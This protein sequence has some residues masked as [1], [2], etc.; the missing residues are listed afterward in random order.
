MEYRIVNDQKNNRQCLP[1]F[2]FHSVTAQR[3]LIAEDD[4]EMSNLLSWSLTRKG[5]QIVSCPD[6]DSLMKKVGLMG[7]FEKDGRFDLIITDIRM[8]GTSGIRFLEAAKM[9]ADFPPVILI[10]AFPD[11]TVFAIAA[12]LGALAI[13]TKPF[14]IDELVAKVSQIL[15]PEFAWEK[16]LRKCSPRRALGFPLKISFRHAAGSDPVTASI[17][18]VARELENFSSHIK[19]VRVVIDE[20]NME[21][22]QKHRY[23]IKIT[24]GLAG[25]LLVVNHDT[26]QANDDENLYLGIHLAFAAALRQ[27]KQYLSKRRHRRRK[28]HHLIVSENNRIHDQAGPAAAM[29]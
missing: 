18:E 19:H 22:H 23:Q 13:F 9:L 24:I 3:I 6:G 10:T 4:I 21:A 15:P 20:N 11:E 1:Q 14:D 12:R 2:P 28:Q 17:M 7:P 25:K 29:E 5:Y 26:D 16:E 8:P 27:L